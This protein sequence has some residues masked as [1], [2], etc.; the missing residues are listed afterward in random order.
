MARCDVLS[1]HSELMFI[2]DVSNVGDVTVNGK[3]L[4]F[5]IVDILYSEI[6]NIRQ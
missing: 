1:R 3:A 6:E 2:G 4:S 5:A